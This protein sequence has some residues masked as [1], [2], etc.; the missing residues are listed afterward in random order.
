VSNTN[1]VETL[2]SNGSSARRVEATFDGTYGETVC[3]SRDHLEIS[4]PHARG[5]NI[6]NLAAFDFASASPIVGRFVYCAVKRL[7]DVLGAL[8]GLIL[9]GPFMVIG[10]VLV[11]M[12]DGGPLIFRQKR[13]GLNGKPFTMLKIRTMVEDAENRFEEVASLN[14]HDDFRSFKA[15]DDPR[16]L[17]VGKLLRKYSIDEFPQLFNVLRGDM[18]LVGPRPSLE[19]EVA[20]Y[21]SEDCIRLTVKPGLTCYWQISG[22]GEIPFKEQVK[23]DRQYIRDCSIA[24]DLAIVFKTFPTLVRASGAH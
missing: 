12:E 18:S 20:L 23:M 22:R 3:V 10:M 9:F 17:K 14:H 13:I 2:R 16:I 11:W 4:L 5:S 8:F 21:D 7:M 24:T 1:L 6:S 19:R 15:K